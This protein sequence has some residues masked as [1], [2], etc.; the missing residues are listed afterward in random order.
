[1]TITAVVF[2]LYGTLAEV[3]VDEASSSRWQSLASKLRR[4]GVAVDASGIE[5]RRRYEDLC[6]TA[7]AA[8]RS[9]RMLP[10]VFR[11]MLLEA[12]AD[13]SREQVT[14]FAEEFRCATTEKLALRD[15]APQLL[16]ELRSNGIRLGLLS[17]TEAI[18]TRFDLERLRLGDSF[19]AVVLSSEVG[20]EKP[21]TDIYRA[22]L[23]RLSVGPDESVMVGDNWSTDVE[24]ALRVGMRALH[25]DQNVASGTVTVPADRVVSVHPDLA[26]ITGGLRALG[27]RHGI[28]EAG[29]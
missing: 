26:S 11:Q 9:G 24:G 19:E 25:L 6:A 13:G 1:M 15:Y 18:L 29:R 28:Q 4:S 20:T 12:G 3:S 10:W 7:A 5:L 17:N 16:A 27:L 23:E 14:S 8:G 2:D 21:S 22:A